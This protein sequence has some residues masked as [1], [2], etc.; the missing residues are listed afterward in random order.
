MVNGGLWGTQLV[1]PYGATKAFNYNLAE[2]LHYE[3]KSRNINVMACC[4]C[5]TDTPNY[6]ST[7]PKKSLLGPSIMI[8]HHV[9]EQALRKL[10]K[11]PLYIPG[12]MNQLTY[13]FLTRVFTRSFSTRFMNRTM[14]KMYSEL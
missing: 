4:A 5:A 13:F 1:V 14:A 9:A 7:K 8:P 12:F 11:K 10:G 3:L 6:R 2:G